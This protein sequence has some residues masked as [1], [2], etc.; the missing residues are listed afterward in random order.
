[1]LGGMLAAIKFSHTKNPAP[2]STATKYAMFDLEDMG[3]LLRCILWPE[4]F[5]A[6]GELVKPDAVLAV[7][8]VIDKRPGSEEANLIV[9]EVIAL[10]DLSTRFTRGVSIRLDEQAH[11]ERGLEQLYEILRGYPGSCELELLL[12][13]SDGSQ[14]TCVCDSLRVELNAE[15]RGRVE[16]LLGSGSLRLLPARSKTMS[17]GHGTKGHHGNGHNGYARAA[18]GAR[19]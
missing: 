16:Q 6:Y 2:G 17:N 3:G 11:G 13:L 18:S 14:V 19:G 4:E 9:N 15:M 1:M 12:R 10:A 7:R 5:A 8:G